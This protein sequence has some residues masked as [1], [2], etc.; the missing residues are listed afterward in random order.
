MG[1]TGFIGL[2][3]L[4]ALIDIKGRDWLI[5][6]SSSSPTVAKSV[7]CLWLAGPSEAIPNSGSSEHHQ[8]L[9]KQMMT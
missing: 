5:E 3:G 4:S 2:L 9:A 6:K 7:S 1:F 8:K